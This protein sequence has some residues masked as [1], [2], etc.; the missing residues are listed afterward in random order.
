MQIHAPQLAA[1][2]AP[3]TTFALL[4]S[5]QAQPARADV[6]TDWNIK[7]AEL[8][9]EARLGTPSAVRLMALLQTAAS[10]AVDATKL[11][12]SI[13]AAVS[14]A[15]CVVLRK[16]LP[17]Q[18]SSVDAV[19]QAALALVADGS[20]KFGGAGAGARAA[21]TLLA[22]RADDVVQTTESYRPHTSAG[23]YV[24][25]GTPAVPQ[26]P[27]RKPWL[28]ANAAQFRPG[29]P[30]SLASTRWAQD[31]DEAKEPGGKVSAKRTAEQTKAARFWEYSLPA[32]YFGIVRSMALMPGRDVKRNAHLFAAV[33]QAMDDTLISVF[34]AKYHYN[35]WRP[36]TAIRN[37]DLD[38]NDATQRDAAWTSLIEAPLHPEYPSAHSAVEAAVAT[39]FRSEI[40]ASPMPVLATSSPTA[41]SAVRHWSSVDDF[42][43]EVSDARVFGG[44]H[45]R[46]ATE[47]GE[48]LGRRVGEVAA[49]TLQPAH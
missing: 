37:G 14:S 32:I 28:L 45:F 9:A 24:P 41:N 18:A 13:D 46:A 29:P 1:R 10:Q 47:A 7:S 33:A 15:H 26:W 11:A 3:L 48:A 27:Q 40:E 12:A 34:E 31:Y 19:C 6:I 30:P 35:F 21:T 8:I 4:L 17:M 2:L 49:A 36:V 38:G 5:Y 44:I 23:T 20:A 42:V 43:R 16:A 25:T 39:V 22:S